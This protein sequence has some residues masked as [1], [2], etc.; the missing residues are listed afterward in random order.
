MIIYNVTTKIHHSIADEWLQWVKEIHSKDILNTECFT[1]FKILKLLETD[2]VEGPTYAV[3]YH[4]ESK[5]LYNRYIEKFSVEMRNA[6]FA[7]WGDKF[8]SFRSV[9]QIVD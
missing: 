8:L 9:M 7:K 5:A 1:D 2:E 6:A 4:A 3:Q